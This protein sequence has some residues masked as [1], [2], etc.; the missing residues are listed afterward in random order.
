M[1]IPSLAPCLLRPAALLTGAGLLVLAIPAHPAVV[2]QY[3]FEGN[4]NDTAAGGTVADNLIYNRGAA[5]STT[6][7]YGA[8]VAGGQA[9]AFTGNWFQAPDS[10]DADIADN[11]WAIET[12]IKVSTHNG[13]WERLIVKWGVSNDY[14]FSLET[15]DLNFFTG[16]PDGNIFDRNTSPVTSFTDGEWHHIAF[17]SSATGSQAWID[18][19]S[20]FTGGPVTLANGS[21]PLGI[22]DFGT[23]GTNNALRQHGF[24]DEI[25][26]HDSAI[27]QTYIDTRVGLIR[28]PVI[29]GFIATPANVPVNGTTT[30]SWT[31]QNATTLTLNGGSFSNLDVSG[32]TSIVTAPLP[33]D[34]TFTLTAAGSLAST[35]ATRLVGVGASVQ[36]PV[37]NEF[38]AANDTG[39]RDVPLTGDREDWIEIYN[40]NTLYS[41]DLDGYH[42]TDEPDNLDKWAFPAVSIPP[43]GYLLVFA[44]EKNRAVAGAPL[45]TNFKLSEN[46]EYLALVK[47]DGATIVQEFAPAYPN[48]T[49]DISYS[50]AGYLATPTPGAVNSTLAGPAITAVT[51]NPPQPLDAD[52][53]TIHAT[54]TPRDGTTVTAANLIY[55]VMYNAEVTVPMTPGANGIYSAVIP[56]SASSPAQMIRW[57]IT[58]TDSA[59][60]NSK[61]PLFRDTTNS[62]EYL[63]TVVQDSSITTQLPVI[64]RFV[65][66]PTGIDSDP[67]TRCSVFYQGEF[68]DNLGIRIRGNTSRSW[69]KK[70]HKIEMNSGHRFRFRAGVPRVTEFDLNTTY[71]DK[72]YVRSQLTAELQLAI[73]MVCPEIWPIHVRQNAAFY[74]VALFTENP[75]S[76]FL[77]RRG[78]DPDGAYYKAPN[79]NTYTSSSTFEQKTRLYDTSKA[80][81]NALVAALA[82]SGIPL[83]TYVFDNVDLPG[84]VN[85]IATTCITQNIDAS[86]KNHFAWR[87]TN[88]SG[89]WVMLPWDLDLTFGPNALNTDTIVY[90]QTGATNASHPFIGAN[91]FLLHAGKNNRFLEAI[92]NTP[93]SRDMVIRRIRSLMDQYL[94]TNW[95]Q[96]RMDQLIPLLDPDVTLDHN[97][98]GGSSHFGGVTHTLLAANNRIKNEY[99]A[100]RLTWLNGGGTVGIPASMPAAPQINFGAYDSN[101]ASANQDQEFIELINPNA[102]SV[103]VSGWTIAGGITHTL[104]SGTV[105]LPGSSLYLTPKSAAFRARTTGPGGGQ[106][107]FVQ[108]GYNG[109]LS[110]FGETLTLKNTAGTDVASLTIPPAPSDAQ[111]FLVISE[112]MYHPEPNG[113][114]EFIELMNISPTVTL[115][116]AGVNFSAGVEFTFPPGTT[117]AP[118][119]RVLVVKNTAAFESVHG[120]GKPVAGQFANL[121]SLGNGGEALKLD[122]A[123]GSTVREFTYDDA[124]PWPLA[125]DGN[126]SLVLIA[127]RTNPD[128]SLAQN[129]RA[130]ITLTGNP[131]ADDALP[132]TGSPDADD[133]QNGWSN[134]MEYALGASP[135]ITH[136]VTPE[137]LT[138]TIP[139][140]PNADDAEITGEISTTLGTWVPATFVSGDAGTLTFRVPS[141]LLSEPRIFVRG[142]VRA[143]PE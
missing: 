133:N 42:L 109:H 40:P 98:W 6:P 122:D 104:K 68:F 19:V 54:L 41:L 8:G 49:S 120:T 137:G 91:P 95:F 1:K 25:R 26:I 11:T 101:P 102:Y 51:E 46:G 28:G 100:P 78:L 141:S 69:P 59:G 74:S 107:L 76:D 105:M 70:S 31:V 88:D 110:N 15:R 128:H 103:D 130:S 22:G 72:S 90:N 33:A 79:N 18:G 7:V 77:Q 73:G 4:L 119:A 55:R 136:S 96:N 65:Q 29:T 57:R 27:D 118:L 64:H 21:D 94:A 13:Q 24:M 2:V 16:N 44:S 89:E 113:D 60:R 86:D 134:F 115:N 10:V 97:K 48:Q 39:L 139:R 121:G 66:T 5:V 35:S 80:D 108:G 82:L 131:D 129:W 9:A 111:R 67:G 81:L 3:S 106:R 61:A 117:L 45:H 37:I 85:Y 99:L 47:P 116:M 142:S 114:A 36:E 32:L 71:T 17:T 135:Q 30:L 83:E 87:D 92:V 23:G 143:R 125:A 43:Q 38:L 52:N 20:V 53:L 12:F 112:I 62:P 34:T 56:A 50:N 138:F 132:F 93:R 127:P 123:T 140:I 58:A 84:M 14:H 126:A 75:D 63:G 124:A